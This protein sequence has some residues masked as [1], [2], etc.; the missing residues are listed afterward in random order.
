[1]PVGG[2]AY[3]SVGNQQS[4]LRHAERHHRREAKGSHHRCARV[5]G[6][7]P[8]N[9]A[10]NRKNLRAHENKKNRIPDWHTQRSGLETRREVEIRSPGDLTMKILVVTEQRQ[11]KWN[12]ASFETLAA[13]QQ[14]AKDGSSAVSGLGIGK[15]MIGDSIGYRNEGGRLVFVRQMFQGKTAAEVTFAGSAPWFASF[16]SGAFRADLLAAHPLGKAPVNAVTVTLS[17]AEIRTKP[18]E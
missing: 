1:M 9:H 11:G 2:G 7:R 5:L 16:Q 12:N 3:D 8:R 10:E 18:L 17:A 6:C 14:I 4:P 13:A 15:G